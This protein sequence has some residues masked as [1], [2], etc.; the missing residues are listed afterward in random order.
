MRDNF[1]KMNETNKVIR[2]EQAVMLLASRRV[3][4]V[5]NPALAKQF[6]LLEAYYQETKRAW[7]INNEKEYKE[8]KETLQLPAK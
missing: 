2:L 3:E 8:F 6:L 7:I 5:T 4:F 1:N